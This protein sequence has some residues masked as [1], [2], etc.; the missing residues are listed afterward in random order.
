MIEVTKTFVPPL[1]EFIGFV[2]EAY[3]TGQLTNDGPLVKRLEEA[4]GKRLGFD[5]V[6]L[7]ANG[8][9]ALQVALQAS[10]VGPQD[11]VVTPALSYVATPAAVASMGA[12]PVLADI[13]PYTLCMTTQE[14]Q[15][16]V[17]DRTRAFLPVHVY[18]NLCD[19][20][21]FE[22]LSEET[23][24]PVVY[25]AAHAFDAKVERLDRLR[26]AWVYSFHAT[27]LFHTVEGGCVATNDA[28]LADRARHVRNFGHD[29]SRPYHF[30]GLGQNAKLS[31]I[32]AAMGLAVLP[33]VPEIISRRGAVVAVYDN[34]L[35]RSCLLPHRAAGN[36]AYY[37]LLF[38]AEAELLYVEHRLLKE[39]IHPRRYF[40]PSLSSLSYVERLETPVADSVAPRLLCLPLSHDISV[41]EAKRIAEIVLEGHP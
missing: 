11:E 13:D 24:I 27:K 29:P 16:A 6:V 8:T 10:Y 28:D 7:T 2:R 4:L 20:G 26:N 15:A 14:A 31:E 23:G 35:R 41:A 19:V 25:D 39:D 37:P 30:K 12:K 38:P 18:G 40:Y 32:H 1:E 9:L 36:V 5:H 17:T 34:L 3:A 33:H 22:D 21:A